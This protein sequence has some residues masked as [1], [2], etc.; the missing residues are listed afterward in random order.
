MRLGHHT[1]RYLREEL[2]ARFRF[3]SD[4]RA[5]LI[6]AKVESHKAPTPDTAVWIHS[7]PARRR[8][9]SRVAARS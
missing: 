7:R 8:I 2:V 6:V 3:D 1:I 4:P 9:G 5:W